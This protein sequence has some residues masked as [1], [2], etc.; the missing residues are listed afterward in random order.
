MMF[1]GNKNALAAVAE[2]ARAFAWGVSGLSR[3]R[4][5]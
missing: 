5:S 4:G 1:R 2:T 3:R